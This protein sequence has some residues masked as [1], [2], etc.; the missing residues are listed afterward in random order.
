VCG[1][2]TENFEIRGGLTMPKSI[3]AAAVCWKIEY[4]QPITDNTLHF[5]VIQYSEE[6]RGGVH[7]KFPGGTNRKNLTETPL[8]TLLREFEEETYLVVEQGRDE[9]MFSIPKG[10]DHTQHFFVLDPGDYSGKLRTEVKTEIEAGRPPERLGPPMW[11]SA[12]QLLEEMFPPHRKVLIDLL[13][14]IKK[15]IEEQRSKK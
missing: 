5:L 11:V 3:F 9:P 1:F 13:P 7:I 6:G 12:A 14:K 8:Q 2:R 15:F 10:P 4:G